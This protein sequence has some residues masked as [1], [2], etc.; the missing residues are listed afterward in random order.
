MDSSD[1]KAQPSPDRAVEEASDALMALADECDQAPL[2]ALTLCA[3]W[4][5]A[6]GDQMPAIMRSDA[7]IDILGRLQGSKAWNY[8]RTYFRDVRQRMVPEEEQPDPSLPEVV[9]ST[10]ESKVTD[11]ALAIISD[12]CGHELFDRGGRLVQIAKVDQLHQISELTETWL[13]HLL[14]KHISWVKLVPT[15]L[16]GPQAHA[17]PPANWVAPTLLEMPK[18]GMFENLVGLS[19]GPVLR[20]DGSLVCRNGFDAESGWFIQMPESLQIDVPEKPTPED[21]GDALALLLDVVRDFPFEKPHHKST[22][23][24]LLLTLVARTYFDGPTPLFLVS[25]TTA[26]SGKDLLVDSMT[27]IATGQPSYGLKWPGAKDDDETEKRITSSYVAGFPCTTWRNVKSGVTFESTVFDKCLTDATYTGR[28]LGRSQIFNCIN[29]MVWCMTGN[30]PSVGG[31][32]SRRSM[33][34]VLAPEQE[35]PEDR[36]LRNLKEYI[37]QNRGKLLSAALTIIRGWIQAGKP[38]M[39]LPTLGSFEGWTPI[40]SMLVW[41]GERDPLEGNL[42]LRHTD[43]TTTEDLE[44]IHQGFQM[45]WGLDKVFVKDMIE[46]ARARTSQDATNPLLHMLLSECVEHQ[47]NPAMKIGHLLAPYKGKWFKNRKLERFSSG[48]ARGWVLQKRD[49]EP[50]LEFPPSET[51]TREPGEEG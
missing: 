49:K 13:R 45:A 16:G 25:S 3:D 35:H 22:A 26:G 40:R 18:R 34:C 31:D 10:K 15:Q 5:K 2:S 6:Y 47:S 9:I 20:K 24:A 21:A 14:S 32:L 37:T 8:M 36:Q 11:R 46:R 4:R 38:S 51:P 30:N 28:I 1:P 39:G 17:A 19:P 42:E 23:L 44:L 7:W 43:D 50:E 27:M 12:V 29:A 41:V 48:N 33:L